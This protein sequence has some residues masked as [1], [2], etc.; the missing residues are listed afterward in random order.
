MLY[1]DL[2]QA[3][4]YCLAHCHQYNSG[5]NRYYEG[6]TSDFHRMQSLYCNSLY[7]TVYILLFIDLSK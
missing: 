1:Y 2:K 7:F 4:G 6:H 3:E 5:E